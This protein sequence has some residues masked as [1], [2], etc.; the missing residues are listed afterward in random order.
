MDEGKGQVTK[1][2]KKTE[3]K[4]E[5]EREQERGKEVIPDQPPMSERQ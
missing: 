2:K 1:K 5:R 3:R 4:R